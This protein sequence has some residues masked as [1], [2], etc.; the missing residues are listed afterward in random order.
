MLNLVFRVYT[1]KRY[2]KVTKNK[3]TKIMKSNKF[4]WFGLLIL[5]LRMLDA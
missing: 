4:I 5:S 1:V 2:N 3:V